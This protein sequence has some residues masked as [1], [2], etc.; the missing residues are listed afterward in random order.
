M[1]NQASPLKNWI[2]YKFITIE[3]K[4][5][6]RWL[7]TGN[8]TFSEPFFDET[9]Y[10]CRSLSENSSLFKSVSDVSVLAEWVNTVDAAEPAAFIFHVSR[11]GSTIISQLLSI[12]KSNIVLSEVPFFD[13]LLR[14]PYKKGSNVTVDENTVK[15]AIRF[16][17][18]KRNGN[19]EQVFI[20]TDSW[21]IFFYAQI[22]KAYPGTP[23]ILLYRS[24]DEV[25]RS[26]IRKRGM[27]SVPGVIE[28]EVFGFG[29]KDMNNPDLDV[30]AAKV[31][32]KFLE[33]FIRVYAIDKNILAVNYNEGIL[34][35][36]KKII[37]RTGTR[38][39]KSEWEGIEARIDYHGKYPGKKFT[40]QPLQEDAPAYL[41]AAMD[42]YNKLEQLRVCER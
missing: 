2:P 36:L 34:P 28:P 20:K 12:G 1:I 16:Y 3:D 5:L 23:F 30:Y 35:I 9:I 13:D 29:E 26:L 8:H 32:E 41:S 18:Q 7:Y 38:F 25:L 42:Y 11:C 15:A 4:Q 27:Q 24:P 17:S 37:E 39:T 40:E 19:E 10:K 33:E 14:M 22:R 21:H 31:L 6:C